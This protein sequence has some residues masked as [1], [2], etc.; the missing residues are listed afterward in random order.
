[1]SE[2]SRSILLSWCHLR[3]EKQERRRNR[4]SASN[5]AFKQD[6]PEKGQ[7]FTNRAKQFTSGLTFDK[8]VRV[9][10]K[11]Q[12]R[13][14][15]TIGEVFLPDGRNLNR[16]VIKAGFAW[17]FKRYAPNDKELERLETEAREAKRGLWFDP[18]PG[19]YEWVGPKSGR[20]PSN[21]PASRWEASVNGRDSS[22]IGRRKRRVPVQLRRSPDDAQQVDGEDSQ[23]NACDPARRSNRCMARSDG[24][25][26]PAAR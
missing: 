8:D 4:E 24:F 13:Y 2:L 9:E 3:H 7:P 12:N 25:R 11:G 23:Q 17:W 26:S 6:A 16:E 18:E 21:I 20:Q 10:T 15:R 14:G 19:F 5:L 1:M 22:T